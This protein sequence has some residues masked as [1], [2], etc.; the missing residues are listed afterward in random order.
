MNAQGLVCTLVTVFALFISSSLMATEIVKRYAIIVA[1][2]DGGKG[3][4]ALRYAETD[5]RSLVKVL[6]ELG[7]L[8]RANQLLLLEPSPDEIIAAISRIQKRIDEDK[9]NFKRTELFFYYSGHS[10]EKGLLLG[11][12]RLKYLRLK[13]ALTE[14]TSD[15]QI[16]VLDSCAS[17]AFTRIKGGKHNPPFMQDESS[18]VK[19]YAILTSSSASENAQES[20]AIGGSYFTHYFVS[21]LRGAGDTTL[22][23]KVTLNE[24]YQYAFHETLARTEQSIS[25]AQHAAYDFKLTGAGDLVLTE[26]NNAAASIQFE[27]DLN[28]RLYVRDPSGR[29]VI[30]I[31]KV[32]GLHMQVSLPPQNYL[33]TLDKQG[34]LYETAFTI[35]KNRSNTLSFEQFQRVDPEVS[36]ARGGVASSVNEDDMSV[37]EIIQYKKKKRRKELKINYQQVPLKLSLVPGIS[38]PSKPLNNQKEMV[39]MDMQLLGSDSDNANYSFGL[40]SSTI[41]E[42]I[43]AGQFA[44]MVSTVGGDVYGGQASGIVSV[45]KG[46]IYGGQGAGVIGVNTGDLIGGMGSGV[47]SLTSGNVKGGQGA[48]VVSVIG[49]DLDGGQ[50]AGVVSIV[51][52]DIDGGQGA[53]VVSIASGDIDGGQGAGVVAISGGNVIGGQGAGI[54]N[55]ALGDITKFQVAGIANFAGGNLAG[56]Q[57]SGLINIS[58]G[59]NESVQI[60]VLNTS[61][62]AKKLQLGLINIARRNDGMALGLVNAIGNGRF[63]IAVSYD[64]SKYSNLLIKSGAQG[65]YNQLSFGE[66]YEKGTRYRRIRWGIGINKKYSEKIALDYEV[67]L[68]T[69]FQQGDSI[70]NCET[71]SHHS[72]VLTLGSTAS[73]NIIHELKLIMG[74]SINILQ[75]SSRDK[76]SNERFFGKESDKVWPGVLLGLQFSL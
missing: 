45:A 9:S 43:I 44:G 19:G 50:G 36:V 8:E 5:A 27:K 10:D 16:A 34:L 12:T 14:V 38:V 41:N 51:A 47:V 3:R 32:A 72:P 15:V 48:G 1:A 74:A 20:D 22:D 62:H 63:D 7:G 42:D 2:N 40:F 52:G 13:K 67:L 4:V 71:C 75:K 76:S 29:L 54:L 55:I 46:N 25:G 39:A 58:N 6:Q 61:K 35:Q 30:E 73:Y 65:I 17:G 53:G 31:S 11:E 70:A 21:A 66:K 57:V 68:S 60:G 59:V 56:P 18:H 49:G 26:L 23:K 69:R 33:I 24:A 64:E 28:G 37:R